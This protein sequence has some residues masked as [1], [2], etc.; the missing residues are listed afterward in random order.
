MSEN[1][2]NDE[3]LAAIGSTAKTTVVPAGP[4]SGKSRTLV[5]R[6]R[7]KLAQGMDPREVAILTF[8]NAG[9]H[10]FAERLKPIR[11]NYMGTVHG[12]CMRLIQN[13]GHLLGYRPNCVSIV[14]EEA[15]KL[16]LSATRERLGRKITDK[17]LIANQ[18]P[19]ARLIWQDYRHWLKR[20]NMVDYDQ[21]LV[22][23]LELLRMDEVRAAIAIR[24][25]LG[26][27]LQDSGPADWEIIWHIP[28]DTRFLVGDADQSIYAFRGGSP[29]IFIHAATLTVENAS[30]SGAV[31]LVCGGQ[32]FPLTLNYR[33][34]EAICEAANKLIRHNLNRIDKP[35]IPVSEITGLI[36]V[37]RYNHE[38]EEIYG[39]W[40]HI[41]ELMQHGGPPGFSG[42]YDEIAVLARTNTLVEKYRETLRGLGLPIKRIGNVRL[43]ADWSHALTVMSLL[44]DPANDIHA[45][46]VL[47]RLGSTEEHIGNMRL[48]AMRDH[49]QLSTFVFRNVP[50]PVTFDDAI[51]ALAFLGVGPES[52]HLI[53]QRVQVLPNEN[54]TL[55][56]LLADLWRND[57]WNVEDPGVGVT[58]CT[59]HAAKGKEFDA[60]FVVAMEEGILP[61][62]QA[63][64]TLDT[65][66]MI[67]A[68]EEE[69]RLA[70][71]AI[72]RARHLLFLSHAAKRTASFGFNELDQSPSRF[73]A[74]MIE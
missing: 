50:Q 60:V 36:Q 59:M 48:R 51:R 10:V 52:L 32:E 73:L 65:G 47:R 28:A 27:E 68:I 24:E 41:C 61:S 4:G 11:L 23:G 62:N 12:Y 22:D 16:L 15:K 18:T 64:K 72:T 67:A 1:G 39:V 58:V 66:D 55:S 56:D 53:D 13:H 34:D 70:F 40:G 30:K 7:F 74:E 6:V 37:R 25:L 19:Y 2:F 8:T 21:I 35:I 5:G 54:P 49:T 71:V 31:N 3:Q 20:A 17:E 46:E 63:L 9:A 57:T 29:E 26:D 69:R 14:T 38:G 42:N 43:P 45:E 33:S 44:V